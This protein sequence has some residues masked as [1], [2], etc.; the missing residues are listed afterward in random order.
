MNLLFQFPT[1]MLFSLSPSLK[2]MNSEMQT[3]ETSNPDPNGHVQMCRGVFLKLDKNAGE[4]W[5]F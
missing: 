1:H 4:K 3:A 2:Q 5:L